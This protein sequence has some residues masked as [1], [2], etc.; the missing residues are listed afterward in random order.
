MTDT[1]R[2]RSHISAHEVCENSELIRTRREYTVGQSEGSAEQTPNAERP[3][4]FSKPTA[5][6][7]L[8]MPALGVQR[9]GCEGTILLVGVWLR[10]EALKKGECSAL[11]C[12]M[13]N[14]S[15]DVGS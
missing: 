7:D 4:N 14:I 5:T 12:E 9:V 10:I 1:A 2:E 3:P 15:L 13:N 6:T 11:A 8:A